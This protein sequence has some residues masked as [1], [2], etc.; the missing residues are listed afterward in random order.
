VGSPIYSVNPRIDG[1]Y[2]P[3]PLHWKKAA[4]SH[5]WHHVIPD[6]LLSKVWNR[7]VDRHIGTEWPEARVTIRQYLTLCDRTLQDLDDRL[8]SVRLANREYL[9]ALNRKRAGHNPVE[10]LS[11]SEAD[12]LA[13]AAVWPAW[14]I[15]GGP[16]KRSDDPKD[17]KRVLP[18]RRLDRFNVGLTPAEQDRMRTVEG[19]FERFLVFIQSGPYPDQD[20]LRMLASDIVIA[21]RL[22]AND[23][24]GCEQPI[25]FR[26]GMWVM[27][28]TTKE[29]RKR[30]TSEEL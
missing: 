11:T 26:P 21:K 20:A 1:R 23:L 9:E 12:D 29:W 18:E 19:L 3:S 10:P 28:E 22:S 27:D 13:R 4:D 7:L 16:S 17:N 15:V 8:D 6:A 30:N 2:L 5:S 14:N 25:E 24:V